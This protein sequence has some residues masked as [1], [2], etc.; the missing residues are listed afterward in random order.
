[1]CGRLFIFLG[2]EMSYHFAAATDSISSVGTNFDVNKK[3][4]ILLS[5][6]SSKYFLAKVKII[7]V[8]CSSISGASS[9]TLKMYSG[10]TGTNLVVSDETGSITLDI[11]ST[12]TGCVQIEIDALLYSETELFY[13]F[14]KVD[15]GSLTIDKI[16]VT[17]QTE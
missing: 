12:T 14:P 16:I 3:N 11:D 4:S 10:N 8:F 5:H 15:A 13:I 17:Y 1:M 2:F 7:S 9:V 6:D